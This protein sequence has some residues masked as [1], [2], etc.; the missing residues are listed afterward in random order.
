MTVTDPGIIRSIERVTSDDGFVLVC[1]VDHLAEFEELLGEVGSVSFADIV[2]AKAAVVTAVAD[3]VSAVLLDPEFGIG[4]LV[5][6]GTLPPR[7]GLISSIEEENYHFADGPRLSVMRPGWSAAK[8][9]AAGA[10]M[11]K[12]LWFYRPDLDAGV[13][14][15]Q[16]ELLASVSTECRAASIPL[17]VEP[18]WFSVP[19]EDTSSV[20]WRDARVAG[21]IASAVEA[22]RI[23][24]DLLKVEFPGDVRTEAGRAAAALACAELDRRV[25]APWVILSAG[26]GYDDFVV[27]LTIASR[28]GACGYMAG[29]SVWR[30][31]VTTGD[32]R[33]VTDRIAALNHVV[34]SDGRPLRPALPLIDLV[35]SLPRTWYAS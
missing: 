28:A 17:V 29:R 21:I 22:E 31:A 6:S 26:V 25:A 23:G 20:A 27:Q 9:K 30:E 24:L 10:D 13:A 35:D 34:R 19:G 2:K 14:R 18:I 3:E 33:S 15:S 11:I 4:H 7:V 32:L 16:R 1:A 12:F 8:A 5:S